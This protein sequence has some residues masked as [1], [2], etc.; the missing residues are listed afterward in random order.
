MSCG[1]K[2]NQ[3]RIQND[4]KYY[5]HNTRHDSILHRANLLRKCHRTINSF[6]TEKNSFWASREMQEN[7]DNGFLHTPR[8]ILLT[9]TRFS[10]GFAGLKLILYWFVVI[11]VVVCFFFK[12]SHLADHDSHG[13]PSKSAYNNLQTRFYVFTIFYF[14]HSLIQVNF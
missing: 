1:T 4:P 6:C 2:S 13:I 11:F 3:K 5:F 8:E 7:H 14:T 12:F 9:E 10:R